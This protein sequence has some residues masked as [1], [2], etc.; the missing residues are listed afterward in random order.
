[1]AEDIPFISLPAVP[2]I[3]YTVTLCLTV[4]YRQCRECLSSNVVRAMRHLESSCRVLEELANQW[5]IAEAMGKMGQRAREKLSQNQ[6]SSVPADN[7][8]RTR[9]NQ[10]NRVKK[11][12][13]HQEKSNASITGRKEA[14]NAADATAGDR[15]AGISEIPQTDNASAGYPVVESWT[16]P[17]AAL[18]S[19]SNSNSNGQE[20]SVYDL[21]LLDSIPNLVYPPSGMGDNWFDDVRLFDGFGDYGPNGQ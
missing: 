8:N 6:Q 21:F 19:V 10:S 1:M 4:S 18:D 11:T 20:M 15:R 5:W 2:V 12:K 3:P 7:A 16:P 14:M 13:D 9:R 17:N